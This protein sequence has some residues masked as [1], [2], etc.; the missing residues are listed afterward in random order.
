V[1]RASFFGDV[2]A[3]SFA[4]AAWKR[5]KSSQAAA[6]SLFSSYAGKPYL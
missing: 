1:D 6:A 2:L 4:A 3:V 5:V